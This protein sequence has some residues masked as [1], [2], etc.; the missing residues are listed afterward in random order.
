MQVRINYVKDGKKESWITQDFALDRKL[1]AMREDGCK[2][3]QI[4]NMEE[5]EN[6]LSKNQNTLHG[7][8]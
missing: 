3:I 2:N 7:R 5:F 8:G 4:E 6:G 1:K